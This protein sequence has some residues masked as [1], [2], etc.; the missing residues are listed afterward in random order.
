MASSDLLRKASNVKRKK[1]RVRQVVRN[2][3][4]VHIIEEKRL[5]KWV[6]IDNGFC[7]RFTA[8]EQKGYLD[9]RQQTC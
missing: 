2:G 9:R 6:E 3:H 1:T 8:I 5:L 4:L 7:N